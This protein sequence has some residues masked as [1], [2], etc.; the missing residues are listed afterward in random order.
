MAVM[1]L[2][3]CAAGG[4]TSPGARTPDIPTGHWSGH[5]RVILAVQGAMSGPPTVPDFGCVGRTYPTS[6]RIDAAPEK[7]DGA[8]RVDIQADQGELFG[9]WAPSYDGR[10]VPV[11]ADRT[12]LVFSLVPLA[13]QHSPHVRLFRMVEAQ[14][15]T[16]DGSWDVRTDPE[17]EAHASSFIVDG[18]TVVRIHY[19]LCT[20]GD[21][22]R[23]EGDRVYEDGMMGAMAAN[24]FGVV[25]WSGVLYGE[26]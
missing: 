16:R 3:L 1:A 22:L 13:E 12:H 14:I 21:M 15:L 25:H 26:R 10:G 6:L 2:G 4:C 8:V 5:A 19:L 18:A 20:F 17:G 7:G 24:T 23:F 9:A 11:A